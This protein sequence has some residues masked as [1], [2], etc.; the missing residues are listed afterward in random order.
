M[1]MMMMIMMMMMMT[2][3]TVPGCSSSTHDAP[4]QHS[5]DKSFPKLLQCQCCE[6]TGRTTPGHSFPH[7]RDEHPPEEATAA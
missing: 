4:H 3:M 6:S 2:S 5:P 7:G 1:H